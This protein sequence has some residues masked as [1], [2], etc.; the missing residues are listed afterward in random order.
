[1]PLA[2]WITNFLGL[3]LMNIYAW[4]PVVAILL[5]IAFYVIFKNIKNQK[6]CFV[7]MGVVI[8]MMG[9]FF[10]FNGHFAWWAGPENWWLA[11]DA[12]EKAAWWKQQ[13]V[14]W[15]FGEWWVNSAPALLAGM[16]F[17]RKET[18]IREWFKK[19][20]WLKLAG[21]LFIFALL[22][23]LSGFGQGWFGYWSEYSGNGP[24]ILNKFITYCCQIP[25]AIWLTIVIFIVMLK[26]NASNPVSR[27]FGNIS[28]ETYLMNLIALEVF[29]FLLYKPD[30]EYGQIP[31]YAAGHYNLAIYLV[32]VFAGTIALA[33]I[34]RFA[35][36]QAK[37]L[38]K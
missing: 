14:I 23:F 2:H 27:F 13:K 25:Q 33:F 31:V 4:Y 28:L 9:V 30:P 11:P 38:I 18:Q 7:L 5:Y 22:T 19:L 26:Y 10:A 35:T 24:G 20:Y 12:F 29:R 21:V 3:T 1:M 16:I 15:F 34:Y 32:C 36:K 17:A 37:K 8:F 6:L